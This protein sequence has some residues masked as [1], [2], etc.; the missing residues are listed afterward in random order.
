MA[1]I[2]GVLRGLIQGRSARRD[3]WEPVIRMFLRSDMLM[4][5]CGESQPWIHALGW[6]DIT[7]SDWHLV[8]GPSTV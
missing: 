7:A 8:E 4:C 5:Q 3:D 1:Q 6:D 2:D